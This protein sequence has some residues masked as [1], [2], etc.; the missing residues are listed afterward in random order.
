MKLQ[1]DLE[2]EEINLEY[3]STQQEKVEELACIGKTKEA[4]A[5]RIILDSVKN[6]FIPQIADK[7]TDQTMFD[8][9]LVYFK[10]LVFLNKFSFKTSYYSS[11]SIR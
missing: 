5:K 1:D 7:M 6:H 10:V 11:T 9:W 8:A 2:Q 4:K 3:C